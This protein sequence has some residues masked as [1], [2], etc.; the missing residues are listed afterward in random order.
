MSGAERRRLVEPQCARSRRGRR[1]RGQ[2]VVEFALIAPLFFTLIF[3]TVEFALIRTAM[4]VEDFAAKNAARIG[5]LVGRTQTNVDMLMCD[6]IHSRTAGIVVAK[7]TKVE[8]YKSDAGGNIIYSGS[9]ALEDVLDITNCDT[10]P[11]CS[12]CNWPVDQRN[13]TLIDADFLGVKITYNYTYLTGFIAGAGS[14]LQLTATSVQRIEPQDFQAY[15]APPAVTQIAEVG[16]PV[17]QSPALAWASSSH[18]IFVMQPRRRTGVGG[19][20]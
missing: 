15:A 19:M 5:S 2:A 4:D 12:P 11:Y 8:V 1:M 7:V 9:T 17:G 6:D 16:T 14:T 3:G 18:D 20:L 10:L 13:D